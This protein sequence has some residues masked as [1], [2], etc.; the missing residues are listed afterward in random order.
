[1]K[2]KKTHSTQRKYFGTIPRSEFYGFVLGYALGLII[3][4]LLRLDSQFQHILFALVGFGIGYYIDKNGQ[5]RCAG[6]FHGR[7]DRGNT[8]RDS[9]ESS[10]NSRKYFHR[11]ST[12]G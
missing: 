3:S 12:C 5:Y 8:G 1:M 7:D 2:N 10:C 4:G 6:G 11:C 9:P